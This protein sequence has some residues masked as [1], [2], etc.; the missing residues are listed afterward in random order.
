MKTNTL[1]K[2]L[3]CV[4]AFIAISANICFAATMDA[5]VRKVPQEVQEQVFIYP[6]VYL[7]DVVKAIATG[8]NVSDKVKAIHDWICDNIA[9]NTDVFRGEAGDQDYK[10]VLVK[11]KA[12]CTGYANLMKEMCRLAN[13]ECIRIDGWSKGFGYEGYIKENPDHS[14]NAVQLG[15][16]WQLIDV[17]WDAGYCDWEHFVKHYSTQWL[18]R[19]PQQFIYSHLPMNE[20][21]QY[22]GEKER[23]TPEK[24]VEEPYIPGKFFEY[25]FSLT[26]KA[27]SYTNSISGATQFTFTVSNSDVLV[28]SDLIKLADGTAT[29]VPNSTWDDKVG[30]KYT[31][32]YD[33][34]SACDYKG[35]ILA[36]K[37]SSPY[38]PDFYPV[39]D[40]EKKILPNVKDLL[41][42]KKITQDE[43]NFFESSF[44]KVKENNRYYFKEDLFD[45]A[46][47]N[48]VSKILKLI[49]TE[50][51]SF[52]EVLSVEIKNADDYAGYGAKT[53]R[54]PFSYT[55][56]T[57][58]TNT[59]LL[60]P[61]Q[62]ELKVG[63]T[64]KFVIES[65]DFSSIA[66]V[67]DDALAV[68]TKKNTK[69]N[70]F[71]MEYTIPSGIKEFPIYVS[72]NGR[73]FQSIW[74]FKVVQ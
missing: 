72:K 53:Q 1:H 19:T 38:N 7:P 23:R 31:A 47:N 71:E 66:I 14:W 42:K 20:I 74:L 12:V 33:I 58:S 48:A 3:F 2:N 28:L 55:T 5:K 21:Y 8:S 65:K 69:T 60:S 63:E 22:L 24:F 52:E 37:K 6:D 50:G 46:R 39:K 70:R 16:K 45:T 56:Y 34:P 43:Y 67:E 64:Y 25:G 4:L 13:I 29:I 44:Y 54:Y 59:H 62:G 68:P 57:E 10:T 49:N 30:T 35:R 11:K 41:N 15:K 40:F 27:P 51:V 36:C 26:K 18:Y 61:L 17:T 32:E 9:Y 73:N